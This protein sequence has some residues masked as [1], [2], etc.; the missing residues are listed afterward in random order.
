MSDL[1]SKLLGVER[2]V[3]WVDPGWAEQGRRDV[4]LA[5][6]ALGMG[7]RGN[8]ERLGA[9]PTKPHLV[10]MRTLP[11]ARGEPVEPER[12]KLRCSPRSW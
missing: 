5:D 11:A 8:G 4:C 1:R 7:H 6:E 12:P 3:G 2:M 10:L 9:P